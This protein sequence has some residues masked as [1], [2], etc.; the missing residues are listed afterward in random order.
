MREQNI[1]IAVCPKRVPGLLGDV[2][3]H[4][5]RTGNPPS[6]SQIA[7]VRRW[8]KIDPHPPRFNSGERDL[9]V[10]YLRTQRRILQLSPDPEALPNENLRAGLIRVVA[11]RRLALD[12][13][14]PVTDFV[15]SSHGV[16]NEETHHKLDLFKGRQI[17]FIEF[18][19]SPNDSPSP[20]PGH[21]LDVDRVLVMHANRHI[22]DPL[23]PD[24]DTPA[25]NG[26]PRDEFE[27]LL[28]SSW[29]WAVIWDG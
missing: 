3:M 27:P 6:L 14:S 15:W 24:S 8:Q 29:I 18:D 13:S 26:P 11:D 7:N 17:L 2:D 4:R 10:D 21:A 25:I 16:D 19:S 20:V 5:V 28:A 23:R 9:E 22:F 1:P 12:L